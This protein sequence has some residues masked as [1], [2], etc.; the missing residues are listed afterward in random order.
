MNNN[1]RRLEDE[2]KDNIINQEANLTISDEHEDDYGTDFDLL[3]KE[4]EVDLNDP[5]N[6]KEFNKKYRLNP[7][8]K[9]KPELVVDVPSIPIDKVDTQKVIKDIGQGRLADEVDF[10]Q[11]GSEF[12]E[13]EYEKK[14]NKI[15]NNTFEE[16]LTFKEPPV[17]RKSGVIY[18]EDIATEARKMFDD[19]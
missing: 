13:G 6:I 18:D 7:Q 5:K 15:K 17:V 2:L 4:A 3:S 14:Q 1:N 11:I 9:N 10:S 16:E 19:F 12:E 8:I